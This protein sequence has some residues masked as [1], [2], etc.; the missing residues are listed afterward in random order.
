[1]SKD[2]DQNSNAPM[3]PSDSEFVITAA[4][5]VM[6]ALLANPNLV[7]PD[8]NYGWRLCNCTPLQLGDYAWHVARELERARTKQ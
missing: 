5:H 8:A 3:C 2:V 1:M 4:I 6:A 7:Q